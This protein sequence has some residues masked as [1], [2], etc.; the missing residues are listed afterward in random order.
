MTAF[1]AKA[2]GTLAED[3]MSRM[4]ITWVT[5]DGQRMEYR[6]AEPGEHY[7]LIVAATWEKVN[8]NPEVKKVLLATGD[9]VLKP[10]HYQEPDPPAAWR[11]HDILTEI[12]SQLRREGGSPE[13]APP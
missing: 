4:G 9:L 6:P 13:A 7:R 8:Q 1:T 2:A 10:D 12:R 5:F 11:Y 3:N